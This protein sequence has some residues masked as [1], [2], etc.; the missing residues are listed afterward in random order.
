MQRYA[1]IRGS[2]IRKAV[3]SSVGRGETFVL[4]RFR[5]WSKRPASRHLAP[6]FAGP[7]SLVTHAF[8]DARVRARRSR[9]AAR[10][11][12]RA[13]RSEP[14]STP[15]PLAARRFVNIWRCDDDSARPARRE[16][17][18]RARAQKPGGPRVPARR[19]RNIVVGEESHHERASTSRGAPFRLG[20]RVRVASET[21]SPRSPTGS[22]RLRAEHRRGARRGRSAI[23]ED[24][25]APGVHSYAST[26]AAF[27]QTTVTVA[28]S[29]TGVGDSPPS[30][31][32]LKKSGSPSATFEGGDRGHPP[33]IGIPYHGKNPGIALFMASGGVAVRM[34]INVAVIYAIARYW[35]GRR[36]TRE[37]PARVCHPAAFAPLFTFH[38]FH[39][40][41]TPTPTHS[42]P[43][44]AFA[45]CVS[46]RHCFADGWFLGR[47]RRRSTSCRYAGC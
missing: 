29:F 32:G 37:H 9:R 5:S 25:S 45:R 20:V 8:R 40:S 13:R 31:Y 10:R 18:L 1:R 3:N 33:G 44:R 36:T 22:A 21:P 41:R 4:V 46:L 34:L 12:G 14:A 11:S 16:S 38:F 27:G 23:F 30:V 19:R 47:T 24:A 17:R 26:A 2:V 43:P 35:M 39:V 28:P 15:T 7:R 42:P 6:R